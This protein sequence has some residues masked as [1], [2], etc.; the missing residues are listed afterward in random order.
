MSY[1]LG[2]DVGSETCAVTLI[3][4]TFQILFREPA[5]LNTK[6]GWQDLFRQIRQRQIFPEQVYVIME[7]TG[8]YSE[9]ISY[10]FHR[11]G[12]PVCVEPPNRIKKAFY[13]RGKTDPVD[14]RQI[15]EYRFRYADKLHPWNPRDEICAHI[16]MLLTAREQ[17]TKLKVA[18]KNINKSFTRR[19]HQHGN[20]ID[21]FEELINQIQENIKTVDSEIDSLIQTNPLLYQTTQHV[22]SIPNV[23][24]LLAVNLLFVTDG[25]TQYLE[26]TDLAAYIGIC[27]YPFES[28]TSVYHR[29]ASDGC[30]PV[31][32][33]KL[34]YL[35]SLRLRKDQ[36]TYREYYFRKTEE[37]KP[38]KLVLNNMANKLLRVICAVIKSG[39]PYMENYR[40]VNPGIF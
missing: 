33:R 27:P 38:G 29:P 34:L 37:G 9:G 17:L 36:K 6:E 18:G 19:Y 14:S 23:G 30:G 10:F 35:A 15:G 21:L 1:A 32:L 4:E 13:E 28:G 11:K 40:S 26:Y 7:A 22:I 39:K 2:I 20:T 3:T 5:L 31:R 12:F 8:V 25:F 16:G 24:F